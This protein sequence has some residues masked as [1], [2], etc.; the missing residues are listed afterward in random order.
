M[1]NNLEA[2]QLLVKEGCDVN[3]EDSLGRYPLFYALENNN[4]EIIKL[5]LQN[6]AD[7]M[8]KYPKYSNLNSDTKCII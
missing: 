3:M 4:Y 6:D 5:L 2:V 8:I 1:S 7:I